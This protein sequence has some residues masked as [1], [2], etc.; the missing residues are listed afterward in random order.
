MRKLVVT[1]GLLIAFSVPTFATTNDGDRQIPGPSTGEK[2]YPYRLE[3]WREIKGHNG[4][5]SQLQFIHSEGGSATL[6][7]INARTA[8][9]MRMYPAPTYQVYNSVPIPWEPPVVIEPW[10]PGP[11]VVEPWNPGPIVVQPWD[12]N[13]PIKKHM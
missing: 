5:P 12:P 11:I 1:L 8:D 6:A 10:N 9:L 3:V 7:V 13:E 4:Q 2:K